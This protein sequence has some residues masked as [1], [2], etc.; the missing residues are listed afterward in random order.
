VALAVGI[1]TYLFH[2]T[3]QTHATQMAPAVRGSAVATFAFC[4]F[5]G[6]AVG[7][8]L[9]GL[10]FDHGG[11]AW[12]LLPAVL[13]VPVAAWGFAEALRRRHVGA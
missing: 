8:M 1:G 2:N 4:L 13:G 11:A 7:V 6:Q 3:L 9:C 5:T 12:L 10:A